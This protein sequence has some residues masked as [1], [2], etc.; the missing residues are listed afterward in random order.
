M[1]I[2]FITGGVRSGKS[3]FA[4]KYA[5]EIFNKQEG[6]SLFILPLE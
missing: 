6:A 4:E 5:L 3:A 1:T 2:I